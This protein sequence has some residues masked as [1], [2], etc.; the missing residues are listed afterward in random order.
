MTEYSGVMSQGW[1]KLRATISL[2]RPFTL[3]APAVGAL[4]FSILALK[5]NG[6]LDQFWAFAPAI[7]CGA[8][9]LSIA[10]SSSNAMNSAWDVEQDKISKPERPVPSGAL[11]E[12]E[13]MSIAFF[14]CIMVFLLA[15]FINLLFVMMVGLV[16]FCAFAYSVPPL[17]TKRFLWVNAL[18]IALPRGFIGPLAT[19]AIVG[20]PFQKP[21]I[22]IAVI[23]FIFTLGVNEVKNVQ[24]KDADFKCGI[25]TLV[26]V[27]GV[28][29]AMQIS[30]V[31]VVLPY[32]MILYLVWR[33]WLTS[34]AIYLL[35]L[36]PI[37]I[38]L[39]YYMLWKPEQRKWDGN[40]SAWA[41][42]YI[43]MI[44]YMIGFCAVYFL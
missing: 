21:F 38:A 43:S 33:G 5:Y 44:M 1:D 26:N 39:L 37:G 36:I 16:M 3:A 25:R 2:L 42:F 7:V 15:S 41:L 29:K 20:D 35:L 40:N 10:N 19:F 17:R 32:I 9:S 34:S 4:F 30:S 12:R 24:D 27:Y 18:T 11:T 28:K 31:F 22:A 23:L 6:Q 13:A 14:G 8:L